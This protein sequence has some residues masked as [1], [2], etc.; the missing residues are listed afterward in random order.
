MTVHT[1]RSIRT[2]IPLAATAALLMLIVGINPAVADDFGN[3]AQGQN[4]YDRTGI[5][6][7][8]ELAMLEQRAAAVQNAGAPVVVYLR[9]QEADFDETLEHSR[10]LMESWD[11]QSGP[12]ARDGVVIFLNLEPD[13]LHHGQL[14]VVA[15]ETHFDGGNLPQYELDRITSVMREILGEEETA[16]GIATGLEMI[17]GSLTIGPPRLLSPVR[18]NRH[19][20]ICPGG[21]SA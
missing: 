7:P 18:L 15:G 21:P 12:D 4:V 17:A 19:P 1:S 10:D 13:D 9:A 5:L 11:V 3:P 14:A 20:P 2:L 16:A 6:T 8:E